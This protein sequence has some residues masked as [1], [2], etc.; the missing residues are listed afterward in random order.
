MRI[1]MKTFLLWHGRSVHAGEEIDL[2]DE[3]AKAYMATGQA[4][5]ITP[6]KAP[7]VESAHLNRS[8]P[9]AMRDMRPPQSKRR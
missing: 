3:V 8:Q 9:S 6:T 4:D 2:P 1:R 7:I 5:A